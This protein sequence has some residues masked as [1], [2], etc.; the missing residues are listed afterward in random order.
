[1]SETLLRDGID[2]LYGC[3]ETGD[4]FTNIDD[5]LSYSGGQYDFVFVDP[6]FLFERFEYW[7][8]YLTWMQGEE[9]EVNVE[10]EPHKQFNFLSDFEGILPDE[11]F[12]RLDQGDFKA[13]QEIPD[14]SLRNLA[15]NA[16]NRLCE[17]GA[18]AA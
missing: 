15:S 9:S 6:I 17:I 16:M 2:F 4:T 10:P 12:S 5:Y 3:P 13:L 1:M 11:I 7:S 14:S 8:D 18:F